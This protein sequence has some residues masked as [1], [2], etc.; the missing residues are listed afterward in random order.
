MKT[1]LK[2]VESKSKHH[3]ST[4]P[5]NGRHNYTLAS[6]R[7]IR[8]NSISKAT[9][10]LRRTTSLISTR[11]T[12]TLILLRLAS[13]TSTK[14]SRTKRMIGIRSIQTSTVRSITIVGSIDG[15][16]VLGGV[17]T[18]LSIDGALDAFGVV[19]GYSAGLF[20]LPA[21]FAGVACVGAVVF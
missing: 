5:Q 8:S 17:E 14:L 2:M 6:V 13:P 4:A 1:A 20:G 19:C 10:R 12:P 3:L 11:R 21:G 9:S 18:E 7:P 15:T 16:R